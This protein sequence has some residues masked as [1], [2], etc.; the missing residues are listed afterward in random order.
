M[1][2]Q[3][4][5]TVDVLTSGS[6]PTVV[7]VHSSMSGARQWTRLMAEHG[8]RFAFRAVNLY[9]YG[10]TP[11]WAHA[12]TPTLD[13]FADA[14]VAA[15]PDGATVSLVGHSFGGAVAMQ[16]AR[17]LAGRV[18]RLV[19]IEPSLFYLLRLH[20][21][22]EAYAEISALSQRMDPS[23]PAAAA[24]HFISYW[25]GPDAWAATPEERRAA[26]ARAV[27]VVV[28]EWFAVFSGDTTREAWAGI[29]PPRTLLLS[30]RAPMR[31]S[32]EIMELLSTAQPDWTLTQIADGGHMAPL[33]HPQLVN[34][35]IRAFLEGRWG[36]A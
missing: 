16:A 19:L 9:G 25:G 30:S 1:E 20:G 28:H 15:V 32:R 31:P 24:E 12:E 11:A 26:F 3:Q 27:G 7:L 36:M 5:A 35:A 18:E 6:G 29:L 4:Q 2:P 13:D 8:E 10:R 22:T 14:V 34:P 23:A 17:K 21:R 33:T